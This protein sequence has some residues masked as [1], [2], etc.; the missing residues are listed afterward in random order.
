MTSGGNASS[1]QRESSTKVEGFG[2]AWQICRRSFAPAQPSVPYLCHFSS[3][4]L[5]RSLLLISACFLLEKYWS[6]ASLPFSYCCQGSLEARD[7]YVPNPSC[8]DFQKY[9]WIGQL[10]G[11]AL[12]G[13]D[14]LVSEAHF[15]QEHPG[16]YRIPLRS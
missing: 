1:S 2:T 7:Y 8:K 15:H 12:R 13:K 16:H 6:S 5:T 10:M 9:E 3:G 14:F 11:A 4:R